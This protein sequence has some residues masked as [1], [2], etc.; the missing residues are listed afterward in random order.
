[1]RIYENRRI[2]LEQIAEQTDTS[3]EEVLEEYEEFS[4]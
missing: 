4:V 2:M 3:I 1:M